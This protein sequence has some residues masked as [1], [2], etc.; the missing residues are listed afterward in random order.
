MELS[1]FIG[2]IVISNNTKQR[3]IIS[4]ITS[5]YI[6]VKTEKTNSSGYPSTYRFETINGDPV[7]R[8]VLTFEDVSLNE[9]FI[10][11]FKKHSQTKDAY[12]EDIGYWM[13]RD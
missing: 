8:G 9:Q 7:S 12:C 1:D 2:K 5:P 3:Y 13:K 6:E 4:K 11:A 10:I